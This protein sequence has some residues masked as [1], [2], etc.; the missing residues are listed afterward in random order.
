MVNSSLPDKPTFTEKLRDGTGCAIWRC[1][2]EH[3]PKM[4]AK[5]FPNTKQIQ[6]ISDR[7]I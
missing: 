7:E 4:I 3:N 5:V 6:V 1:W 2:T